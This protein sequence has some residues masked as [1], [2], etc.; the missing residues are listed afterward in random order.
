MTSFI[1]LP[2]LTW[3]GAA[4]APSVYANTADIIT[5]AEHYSG[6]TEIEMRGLG[7]A[8]TSVKIIT[9]VPL[10]VLLDVLGILAETPGVRSWTDTM[11]RSWAEPVGRYLEDAAN[12]ERGV[13][14]R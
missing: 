8:C 13:T 4:T 6:Q 5:L 10:A 14:A 9:Y 11:K 7:N 12:R 1:E 3:N 2:R